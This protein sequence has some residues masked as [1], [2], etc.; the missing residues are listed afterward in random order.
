MN[1]RSNIIIVYTNELPACLDKYTQ[2]SELNIIGVNIDEVQSLKDDEIDF[3]GWLIVSENDEYIKIIKRINDIFSP[4]ESF[5]II[6]NSSQENKNQEMW[7]AHP[8]SVISTA[9]VQAVFV[10][11]LNAVEFQFLQAKKQNEKIK[12][13]K[14]ANAKSTRLVKALEEQDSALRKEQEASAQRAKSLAQ[15]NAEAGRLVLEIEERDRQLKEKSEALEYH[16]RILQEEID[17]ATELQLQLLPNIDSP[18]PWLKLFDRYLPATQLC[19]DY[20]DYIKRENTLDIIIAD[21]TGH[22]IPAALVGVQV[23][24]MTRALVADGLTPNE[25]MFELNNFILN[26]FHNQYFMTM[27]FIRIE[28][29]E[30]KLIYTGAGHN[31]LVL[32]PNGK[33]EV[34]EFLS[35]ALPLGVMEDTEYITDPLN[36]NRGDR[37]LLYTDGLTE[38]MNNSKLWGVDAMKAAFVEAIEN[39]KTGQQAV[40]SV[41]QSAKKYSNYAPFEDDVTLVIMEL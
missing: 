18:Y 4:N 6:T 32:L 2:Q 36:V 10:A 25:I 28:G 29:N 21:V 34:N 5:A 35:Q 27:I 31:P 9:E 39:G 17:V 22:G 20:Y 1:N 14:N 13:I 11:H 41:I 33:S 8:C 7:E 23:R 24:A 19:G 12:E 16:I 30:K 38:A 26:T 15:A 37:I 40:D 3:I